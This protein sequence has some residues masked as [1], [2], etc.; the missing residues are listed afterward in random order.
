MLN[1]CN[2]D[3]EQNNPDDGFWHYQAA[4]GYTLY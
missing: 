1:I 2:F 3:T 4:L